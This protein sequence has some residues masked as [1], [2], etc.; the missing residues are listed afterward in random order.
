MPDRVIV[1]G[2]GVG[3]FSVV[4]ELRRGGFAGRLTIVDPGGTPYDRPPLSKEYLTGDGLPRPAFVDETWY[5][6]HEVRLV[7]ASATRIRPADRTVELDGGPALRADS[8]V[9]SVGAAARRLPVP[10]GDL[11]GLLHLRTLEDADR[12]R[13]EL[14]PGRHLAV[15]G[16]GL[17]GAE[18]AS[19]ARARGA[20]ATLVDP[21]ALPLAAA[22]GESM[23]RRLRA[24]HTDHGVRVVTASVQ[25]I[26]RTDGGWVL[27][28]NSREG[29][30]TVEADAVLV[31][32]G[33]RPRTGLAADAGLAL[34]DGVVVGPDRRTSV[35]Q[36]LAVGDLTRPRHPDGRLLRRPEHW[37]A[38]V[39][40]GV[41]AA[42]SL[43]GA[44]TS[45]APGPQWFWSDRYGRHLE[46]LGS[47]AAG[48][49]VDRMVEGQV[50]MSF[51]LD[52][53]NR[54]LGV[55]TIDGGSAIRAARR[56]I[57]RAIPVDPAALADPGVELRRLAR[58]SGR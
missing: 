43:T 12:L 45:A 28:T 4:H 8:V 30:V 24:M 23:A 14:R 48:R 9:L 36:I 39:D 29:A 46:A 18:V 17:I 5:R 34:D 20:E 2:G 38:A 27:D 52:D 31:A 19:A 32:I 21:V 58:S 1:I 57:E 44:G 25:R 10:G 35:P 37:Q 55:A 41:A 33:V 54:L 11:P 3:G 50:A 53:D 22:V 40:A 13:A 47:M 6:D 7:G 49:A 26:R 42:A 16:A 51:R 15:V 56:L